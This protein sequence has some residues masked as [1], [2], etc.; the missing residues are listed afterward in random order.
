MLAKLQIVSLARNYTSKQLYVPSKSSKYCDKITLEVDGKLLTNA[1]DIAHVFNSY[2]VTIVQS[3]N[4][5]PW[6]PPGRQCINE[7]CNDGGDYNINDEIDDIILKYQE[8]PSIINI[9][10]NTKDIDAFSFEY[11]TREETIKIIKNS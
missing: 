10:T 1:K 9:K 4:I 3:L 5:K 7:N 11:V 6:M 2:F 8:H